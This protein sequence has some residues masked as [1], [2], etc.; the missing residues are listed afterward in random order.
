MK[1]EF[2]RNHGIT[3][4]AVI[5]AIMAENGKD[6]NAA[7]GNV[8]S[9]T[10]QVTELQGQLTER[11]NQLKEL[12]KSVKDNEALTTK[13]TELE[14]AN[15]NAATEYQNK[16]AEI[17]KNHAIE[18]GVRDAKA[19]NVKAVIALLDK[20]KI[21]YKDNTLTG[22]TEQLDALKT[23]EDTGFLFVEQNNNPT[24]PAG[25]NP[26]NP[27]ANSGTPPTSGSLAEAVA[28]ALGGNK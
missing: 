25:T 7:K 28:K 13:I 4:Q 3:D 2:L 22:L 20:E 18:N 14:T 26:N 1:T 19:K 17:Q 16:I 5:D 9:L 23:G 15:Q 6:I 12:K 8:E 24:P 21:T 27:P 11:D 10:S